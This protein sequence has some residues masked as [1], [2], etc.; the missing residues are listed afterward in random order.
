[1]SWVYCCQAHHALLRH[2]QLHHSQSHPLLLLLLPLLLLPL[3]ELLALGLQQPGHLQQAW[4]TAAHNCCERMTT[5]PT[6]GVRH[7]SLSIN[8]M[9]RTNSPTAI[10]LPLAL[11]ASWVT[12]GISGDS[13]TKMKK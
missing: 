9:H 5:R 7:A 10:N 12:W 4:L 13:N 8:H 11:M 1:M 3:L 6:S 2:Q